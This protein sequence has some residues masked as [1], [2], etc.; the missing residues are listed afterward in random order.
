MKRNFFYKKFLLCITLFI[1]FTTALLGNGLLRDN[2]KQFF[3]KNNFRI[4]NSNSQN[5][6]NFYY[7]DGTLKSKQFYTNNNQKTGVWEFYYENGKI[8]STVSFNSFSKNEEAM[9]QNYDKNGVLLSTGKI[10]NGE[11]VDIWKYYD[12]NGKLSYYFNNSNG[13]IIAFDENEKPI[14]KMDQNEISKKLEEIQQEI[15]ND[16]DKASEE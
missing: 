13:E 2:I 6:K 8:K 5:P 10:I 14:L 3:N 7:P 11:M 16:R 15:R 1:F 12:E 4:F 9:I